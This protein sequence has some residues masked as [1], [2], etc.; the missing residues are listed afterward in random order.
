M[1]SILFIPKF[2]KAQVLAG[3]TLLFGLDQESHYDSWPGRICAAEQGRVFRVVFLDR[4]PFE[5][6]GVKAADKRCT[7]VIICGTNNFLKQH[8]VPW[9]WFKKLSILN[10]KRNELIKAKIRGA[11]H[12]TKTFQQLQMVQK[13]PEKFSTIA[14]RIPKMTLLIFK[15]TPNSK[16]SLLI[17]KAHSE[18]WNSSPNSKTSL[19]IQKHHSEFQNSSPN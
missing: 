12:S 2:R 5:L 16:S 11:F 13:F 8:L 19:R 4:K 15:H 1:F 17:L 9:Y 18:F 3:G 14:L 10:A 6:K 7:F